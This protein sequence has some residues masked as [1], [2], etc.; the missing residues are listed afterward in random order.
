MTVITNS[1]QMYNV[2]L[3]VGKVTRGVRLG[4]DLCWR[5]KVDERVDFLGSPMST[6]NFPASFWNSNYQPSKPIASYGAADFYGAAVEYGPPIPGLS[7]HHQTDP[8]HYSLQP[9]Q[10]YH[11]RPT[12]IP[13]PP[14]PST[15]R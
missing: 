6:R 8:W 12:E 3:P 5:R 9:H 14:M 1:W 11:H 4:V 13:Y 15:S 10:G 7:H 2:F